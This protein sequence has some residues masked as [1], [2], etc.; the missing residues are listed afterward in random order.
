MV[1]SGKVTS[2]IVNDKIIANVF[3]S[4]IIKISSKLKSAAIEVTAQKTQTPI[5]AKPTQIEQYNIA[6]N[7]PEWNLHFYQIH[8]G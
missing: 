4:F 7:L 1:Q 3:L 2:K 6:Q 5:V 8:I